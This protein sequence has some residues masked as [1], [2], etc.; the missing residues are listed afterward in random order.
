[1]FHA[2]T[3]RTLVIICPY[4]VRYID[5]H[6]YLWKMQ[7]PSLKE[8]NKSPDI[9]IYEDMNPGFLHIHSHIIILLV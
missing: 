5:D 3:N 4:I 2:K 1:M 7:M 6:I 8:K 9:K